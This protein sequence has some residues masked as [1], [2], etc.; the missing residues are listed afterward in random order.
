MPLIGRSN[1]LL[2]LLEEVPKAERP[3]AGKQLNALKESVR[4]ADERRAAELAA[5]PKKPARR[6]AST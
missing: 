3:R 5:P 1:A 2:Q 4:V 6:R